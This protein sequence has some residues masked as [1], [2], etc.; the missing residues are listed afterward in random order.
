MTQKQAIQLFEQRKVRIVWDDDAGKWYVAI[1]D[2]VAVLTDSIDA[3]EDR[4]RFEELLERCNIKR[5]KGH[6]VMTTEEALAAAHDLGYPVLMRPS[7]VLGG[8]NM[9]IAYGDEDINEYMAIIL[10]HSSAKMPPLSKMATV[11]SAMASRLEGFSITTP[12][13]AL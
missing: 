11:E 5:P 1:V 2:V 13:W 7:Y 10:G 3:A 12:C 8:Q 4:E 9:I 6:T